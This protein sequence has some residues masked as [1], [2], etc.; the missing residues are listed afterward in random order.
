MKPKSNQIKWAAIISYIAIFINIIAGLLYTPW[1]I[2]QIGQSNYG[3]YTLAISVIAFFTFDFGLGETVARFLSRYNVLKDE[4]SKARFLGVTF[5]LYLIIDIVI[6]IG[7]IIVFLFSK[8]FFPELSAGELEKFRI[9]FIIAGLYALGSFPFQPLNG[10][11]ISSEKFIFK[12]ITEL[13]H[14]IFTVITMVVVLLLGYK[15]YALVT[16]NAITGI[17]VIVMK[18]SYIRKKSLAKVDF[19]VKD[20]LYLKQILIFSGWSAVVGFASRLTFSVTPT[21]LAAVSGTIHIAYFGIASTIEGYF[22]TFSSALN[23][24]F[25]PK[26]TRIIHEDGANNQ[27]QSLMVKVGRLQFIIIGLV[28]VGFIGVGKEFLNLWLNNEYEIVY[29]AVILMVAPSL[30]TLTQSIGS[31]ALTAQNQVKYNA[32]GMLILGVTSIILSIIFSYF[33]GVIGSGIGIFIGTLAGGIVYKNI[34][35]HKKL[36]INVKSFFINVHLKMIVPFIFTLVLSYFLNTL[37]PTYSWI[38]LIVKIF[39]LTIFYVIISWLLSLNKFEKD[40][41]TRPIIIFKNILLKKGK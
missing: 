13:V 3:L 7:F 30:I 12:K 15:L 35:Y 5:K 41:V 27:L 24:L 18:L 23:G 19:T 20:K 10:I 11:L 25:L 9:V 28:F 1:M 31:T 33:Y 37:I 22:F 4:E 2:Q 21:I 17:I 40:L 32:I 39:T 29:Y 8:M 6:F 34:I 16:V 38:Y 14:R 26:V 36:G